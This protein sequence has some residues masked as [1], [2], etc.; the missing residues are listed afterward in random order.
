MKGIFKN[1]LSERKRFESMKKEKDGDCRLKDF[2]G[3]CMHLGN[4]QEAA[5]NVG[6]DPRRSLSEGL[7]MMNTPEFRRFGKAGKKRGPQSNAVG[8]LR[9]LAFGRINDALELLKDDFCFDHAEKLDLFN[10]SE[11]KRAKGGGV[12][13][14]FFDRL[15][16]LEKLAELESAERG[17]TGADSFFTALRKSAADDA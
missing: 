1:S 3:L 5:I 17:E 16:A 14:K 11:I 9:R 8:G 7:K 6:V 10:V 13:V 4:P 15:E 12:E 2:A